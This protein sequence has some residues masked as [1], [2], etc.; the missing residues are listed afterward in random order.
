M[1]SCVPSVGGNLLPEFFPQLSYAWSL[2]F[3]CNLLIARVY[4]EVL[5]VDQE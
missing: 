1:G 5:L 4:H 3:V 2:L